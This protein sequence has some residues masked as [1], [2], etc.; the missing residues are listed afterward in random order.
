[1]RSSHSAVRGRVM[2]ETITRTLLAIG[3]ASAS[4][5][6]PA[7]EGGVGRS[8]VGAQ[9]TPY[10]GVIPSQ[11]GFSYSFSYLYL[12]GTI[13]AGKQTPIAGE[14]ALNLE[15]RFD[16]YAASLVYIWDTGPSQWNF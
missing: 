8:F 9:I 2:K 16:L 10:A 15:A 4:A 12:D 13:G 11:P 3:I 6:C 14:V 7:V 1:M 5:S